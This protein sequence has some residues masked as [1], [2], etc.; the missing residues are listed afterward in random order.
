MDEALEIA[1]KITEAL[2]AAHEQGIVHR[3]LKPANIKLT[4]DDNV[5]VLDF[6]LA[7]VFA[8]ETPD[9]DSSTSPTVTRLRQG[10]GGQARDATR[11]GVILG[12]AAYM[13]PEQAKGKRVDKRTDIFA[14]GAVVY[15]ML[16]GKKTFPG[17]DV[18]EVLAAVIMLEP[19][20]NG[21][22]S[23]VHPWL[24]RLLR[25][26]L[27][28]D[29]RGRLRDIGD[30]RVEIDE[31]G[32]EAE[33]DDAGS[34]T[35]HSLVWLVA[36][37][38]V[39]SVLAWAVARWTAPSETLAVKRFSV[40]LPPDERLAKPGIQRTR[41]LAISPSGSHIVYAT[42]DQLYLRAMD[43]T[44]AVPV[45]GTEAVQPASP[46]F[47]ADGE[48]IGFYSGRDRELKKI[49]I[50]GGVAISIARADPIMGAT[51]GADDMILF[52]QGPG[53]IMQVSGSGGVPEILVPVNGAE[54]EQARMPQ[55]LPGKRAV[56]FTLATGAGGAPWINAQI[57][58][59][60][61]ESGAR[62]VLVEPGTDARYLPTGYLVYERE[63]GLVAV[64]FDVD[65]LAV[66]GE[67]VPVVERVN[68]PNFAVAD[69]GSLVFLRSFVER[70]NHRLV[71]VDRE[72]R[73]EPLP[74]E[75]GFYDAVRISPDGTRVALVVKDHDQRESGEIYILELARET[76]TR[77]TIDPSADHIP[78]WA[79]DTERLAFVS[80]RDGSYDLFMK[81]ADGTGEAEQLTDSPNDSP[82][83]SFTS[84][85][86]RLVF[87]D[88]HPET[89]LD[90]HLMAL[91]GSR[92]SEVLLA[93]EFDEWKAMLS[94]DDR[95]LAYQSNASG[96]IEIYLRPFPAVE[97]GRW[98]LSSGGGT[99]PRWAPDG[100]EVFYKSPDGE[101]M[102]VS[103][104]T[105]PSVVV[106]R[107]SMLFD[108]LIVNYYSASDGY[109]YDIAPEGQRFLV[110]RE[111]AGERDDPLAGLDQLH[112]VLNWF[113]ELERLVPTD[114]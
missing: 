62:R 33:T 60:K 94:P 66:T 109:T 25:R 61:L 107:P 52:G 15:E 39:C 114:N 103:I 26:C 80:S 71:W 11:A 53:G 72:R 75:A 18:S 41:A 47:S 12:T 83:W 17:R 93:T 104:Q 13:S 8:E 87:G 82:P 29:P 40:V 92:E 27:Q 81:A 14:F 3:D 84:D 6:G 88:Y 101:L 24:Q 51:W 45:A 30:A 98:Q 19:N 58:V 34:R 68:R 97:D 44:Q 64:P 28:K 112:V 37:G 55:L 91:D 77:L 102:A 63:Q 36:M 4:P 96:Q 65:R 106:G 86:E 74:V 108:G 32:G 113:E 49:A 23:T 10:S 90:L 110:I 7:K 70:R 59:Q 35:K 95:W 50:G 99:H 54:G 111:E 16:T 78:T 31:R 46:F 2:E 48:W 22:P 5:K 79:P 42:D 85:G 105:E 1:S 76:L 56:L 38:V 9:A 73:E 57:V 69:D 89:G 21:L 100:R 43:R 67:P 20:W